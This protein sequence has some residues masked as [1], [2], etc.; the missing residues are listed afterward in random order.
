MDPASG[1]VSA[2]DARGNTYTDDADVQQGTSGS[3]SG[4][5]EVVLS[6]RLGTALLQNDTITITHPSVAARTAS[7][8]EFSGL[9]ATAML[10]RTST[11]FG[12]NTTS[13]SSGATATTQQAD[14]LLFGAIGVETNT[15]ETFT[16]GASFT[17]L[18]RAASGTGG[19]VTSHVSS[20]PE[21]QIVAATAAYTA[22]GTLGT[23][24]RWA[25][26]IATYRAARCG[27][28]AIEPGEQCDDGNTTNGDCC[29]AACLFE[30]AGTSCRA[31]AGPCDVAETCTGT[32]AACP[33]DQLAAAGTTCRAAAGTCDVAETCTGTAAA[34]PADAF[35]AAGT[36]C[37]AAAG[38]CDVAETCTGTAA[39]CPADQLA[40]AGTVCRVAAG[41]CDVAET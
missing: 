41:T 30:A 18:T 1:T 27:N 17:A 26:A 38:P 25:A 29:S 20:D 7:V 10:D 35:V 32:S 40:A 2:A 21:L 22:T 5:R 8:N 16:A 23:S 36:T 24:R 12:N 34:C 39:A 4:V 33:A 28:G 19:T 14:E 11:N 13:V 31:S 3:G 9:A 6:A 37:R 15:S